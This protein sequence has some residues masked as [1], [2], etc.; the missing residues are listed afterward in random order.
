MQITNLVVF[1]R[2]DLEDEGGNAEGERTGLMER[3]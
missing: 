3:F 2:L 1:E